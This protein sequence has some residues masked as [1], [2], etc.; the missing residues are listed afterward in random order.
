M[1]FIYL[2][3]D[4][5]SK[6]LKVE[7]AA[8]ALGSRP[9][10]FGNEDEVPKPAILAGQDL[11][12]QAKIFVLKNLLAKFLAD[13][14][15][16]QLVGTKNQI[17]FLEEKLDKRLAQT[18]AILKD[19]R[20][21]KEEFPLPHGRELDSWL[22]AR[23]GERGASL[24]PEAAFELAR[25][26]GRDLS[27]ET[28]AGGKI[29]AVEEVYNLWQADSE[30]QKLAAYVPNRTITEADVRELVPEN[31]EVDVFDLT[32]AVAD[33]Q[34]QLALSLLHKFLAFQTGSEE[35]AAAIQLSALLA[36]QFR[37][38]LMVQDLMA[39]KKSETEI[40]DLTGWKPG[41]VFVIK[42]IAGRFSPGKIR[43]F[44]GKLKALDEELKTGSVPP[45]VLLDLITVQLL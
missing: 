21:T 36:E 5:F 9:V 28:K 35:K 13:G 41:R 45:K 10:F 4:D 20:M 39:V 17:F 7:K 2:G 30:I 16:Q 38:V 43:D 25:R 37:N 14:S 40:L 19:E 11:F 24:G 6:I 29:V 42:K 1:I 26:L 12:S 18:K 34:K 32:N 44:L 27:H 22:M 31:G 23:A 33:N 15:W 3:P 8:A